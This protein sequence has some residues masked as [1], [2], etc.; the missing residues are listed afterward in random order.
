MFDRFLNSDGPFA[1]TAKI[2]MRSLGDPLSPIYPPT[3]PTP[4]GSKERSVYNISD[5]GDTPNCCVLDNEGSQANRIEEIFK[6]P[7]YDLVPKVAIATNGNDVV[8]ALDLNHRIADAVWR[9]TDYAD[10]VAKA[11]NDYRIGMVAD[12]I[13]A[14]LPTSLVFGFW[15]SRG[16][17]TKCPRIITSTIRAFDV[18]VQTRRSQF[19]ENKTATRHILETAGLDRDNLSRSE[20]DA[21]QHQGLVDCPNPH[22]LGG[23]YV[24]GEIF[25]EIIIDFT[26]VRSLRSKVDALALKQYILG[27][28]LVAMVAPQSPRLRQGCILVPDADKPAIQVEWFANGQKKS[29]N[30]LDQHDEILAFAH[31]SATKFV[32]DHRPI[33]IKKERVATVL[34]T[35]AKSAKTKGGRKP[36]PETNGHA[37]ME[38]LEA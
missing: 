25:R 33:Q 31:K 38:I 12:E 19:H 14:L 20:L 5:R 24:R 13:V 26:S 16:S 7:P 10:L 35:G 27:L 18:S 4:E 28:T 11:M 3:Y 32:Q 30:L 2:P 36:K 37:D 15:D 8:N 22:S 29:S 1:F 6:T 34:E 23:V 21:L 17:H 9:T